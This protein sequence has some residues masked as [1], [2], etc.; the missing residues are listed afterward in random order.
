MGTEG[1]PDNYGEPIFSFVGIGHLALRADDRFVT[2]GERQR[3][4]ASAPKPNLRYHYR[5]VGVDEALHAADLL[6][7]RSQA[8]AAVL[9]HA[10]KY[11]TD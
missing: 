5:F 3:F 1:P 11:V 9:C 10:T 4:K 7:P 2:E 8:F 6:P